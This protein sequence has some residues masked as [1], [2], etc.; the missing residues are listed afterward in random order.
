M[1]LQTDLSVDT[2]LWC[3]IIPHCLQKS[4]FKTTHFGTFFV[5][6]VMLHGVKLTSVS[7]TADTTTG[8]LDMGHWHNVP[9]P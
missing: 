3:V 8:L 4:R 7:Y 5:I 1:M 9:Y 6:D 2:L